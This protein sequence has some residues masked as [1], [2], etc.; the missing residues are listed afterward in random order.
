MDHSRMVPKGTHFR[1]PSSHDGI[2]SG[3]TWRSR[4]SVRPVQYYF[5]D[6]GISMRCPSQDTKVLGLLSQDKTVPELSE[7]VP[8]NPF[9]V[10]IYQL[11]NVFKRLTKVSDFISFLPHSLTIVQLCKDLIFRA[12]KSGETTRR[13]WRVNSPHF[14]ALSFSERLAFW[15]DMQPFLLHRGYRLRPRYE[16]NWSP[17]WLHASPGRPLPSPLD[18][19]EHLGAFGRPLRGSE[20]FLNLALQTGGM[21]D[22]VR[23]CDN[24][25]VVFKKVNTADEE[26][27]IAMFLSSEAMRRDPRNCAVPVLDV[28][29]IPGDDDYA[30]LVMPHLLHFHQL[31]FRRVGEFCE[32]ALRLLEVTNFYFESI[33]RA[34]DQSSVPTL[35]SDRI[36]F[37]LIQSVRD[38]CWYNIMMDH[39][40]MVPK[41]TH[42]CLPS[43]HDGVRNGL[44]WKSRW[45]V[46]PVQYYFIDFGISVRCPSPDTK[47]LG[48]LAQ[49]KTTPELSN[50]VPYSPFPV[51]IYQIGN[52]FKRII[53]EYE[54]LTLFAGLAEKMVSKEP[55]E[56]PTAHEAVQQCKDLIANAEVS[57]ETTQRIWRVKIPYFTPLTFSERLAVASGLYNPM[58]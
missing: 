37:F 55:K 18:F 44:T 13:I 5:I 7:S 41:G 31:P 27:P 30:L 57:G 17:P 39:S 29:L 24:R 34:D 4:W 10:D 35:T 53:K 38:A 15:V 14:R 25:K 1:R 58:N 21:L 28:I 56:R 23:I 12:E 52:V 43:S 22:A 19:E 54:G 26:L 33:R 32:M 8:Y 3:L 11:G 48:V 49:D 9:P 36:F 6:F 51:D 2:T 45:S 50:T 47:V 40:K 46:R 16:P 20:W 42:F